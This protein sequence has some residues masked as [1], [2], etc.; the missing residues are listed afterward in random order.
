MIDERIF[1]GMCAP[2]PKRKPPT[3]ESKVLKEVIHYLALCR[4]GKVK[5]NNV[6]MV[7]TGGSTG[8]GRPVRFGTP[9]E[10][11]VTVEITDSPMCIHVECKAAGGKLSD[12]QVAWLDAQRR[13]GHVCLVVYGAEDVFRGLTAAGFDVPALRPSRPRKVAS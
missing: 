7:W 12:H 10:A 11:D 9:G 6:G 3:Q 2:K 4:L 13:R 5:R 8:Q 1:G